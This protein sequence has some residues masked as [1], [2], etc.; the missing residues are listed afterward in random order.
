MQFGA[1]LINL[2]WKDSCLGAADYSWV[3]KLLPA[4]LEW[5]MYYWSFVD[6]WTERKDLHMSHS[7]KS[8]IW[9]CIFSIGKPIPPG[10]YLGRHFRARF[11]WYIRVPCKERLFSRVYLV[12]DLDQ[13][14]WL[15]WLLLLSVQPHQRHAYS[16]PTF[17]LLL[18]AG[19]KV[20][21]RRGLWLWDGGPIQ[22]FGLK[23]AFMNFLKCYQ[24]ISHSGQRT[25]LWKVTHNHYN[26]S[27]RETLIARNCNHE[28][29]VWRGCACFIEARGAFMT[30]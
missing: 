26:Q 27:L 5:V 18:L 12:Q 21:S 11:P 14:W 2:G 16:K 24:F 20:F 13:L 23:L 30:L 6:M 4:Q 29:T 10:M 1:D 19:M 3:S 8:C 9:K 25:G 22:L 17:L 15:C 28:F 7:V